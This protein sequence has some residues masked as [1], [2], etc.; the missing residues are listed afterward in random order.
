MNRRSFL[1]SLTAAAGALILPYEPK[2]V[3]SFGEGVGRCDRLAR[4]N[5]AQAELFAKT[6]E[7]YEAMMRDIAQRIAAVDPNDYVFRAG[8]FGPADEPTTIMVHRPA[9]GVMSMPR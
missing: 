7:R 6:A 8:D 9:R 2:R 5:D 3:Y 4:L 1:A